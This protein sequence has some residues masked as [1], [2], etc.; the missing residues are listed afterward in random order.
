MSKR[1]WRR[2]I[3]VVLLACL[4]SCL[5]ACGPR[6]A[7]WERVQRAGVLR[8][9]LDPTYPPFEQL[10]GADVVGIDVDLAQ[11][12]GAS[13]GL[14]V[15]F[16]HY[17]YDGLYDAL[18]VGQVDVLISALVVDIQRTRDF[19]YSQPY[20]NAGQ[21]V[22]VQD[23][24]E[25]P[26]NLPADLT[27]RRLAVELGAEGHVLATTWQRQLPDLIVHTYGAPAEAIQAVLNGVDDAAVVDAISARLAL[28][29]HRGLSLAGP[30]VTAEPL[31][32]VTRR[33]DAALL[34]QLDAA[35]TEL[36]TSG[37]LARLMQRWLWFEDGG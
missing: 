37:H 19:A 12:L 33:D 25:S 15:A 30:P 16:T 29:E 1:A 35:L 26:L 17:G 9:G 8:V 2:C 18:L 24:A 10:S 4:G 28:H 5:P 36:Q 20:F 23:S 14:R 11:A 31:A 21:V 22:V 3:L 32:L 6:D 13:L 27:G 7:S 34:A